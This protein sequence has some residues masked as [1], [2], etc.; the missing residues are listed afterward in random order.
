MIRN[1]FGPEAET[2]LVSETPMMNEPD[3]APL[4]EP[5]LAKFVLAGKHYGEH[6][7]LPKEMK[8][9]LETPMLPRDV[10]IKIVNSLR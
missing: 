7:S 4:V 3:A 9:E 10:Y 5:L 2:I 8:E 1:K 6:L